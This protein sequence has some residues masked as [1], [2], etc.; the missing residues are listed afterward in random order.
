MNK[1]P[2]L[3]A[4]AGVAAAVFALPTVASAGTW[5]AETVTGGS[6]GAFTIAG[7]TTEHES[8]LHIGLAG[9]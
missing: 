2:M 7:G 5:H 4:L 3:M 1:K 9:E 8:K 6:P